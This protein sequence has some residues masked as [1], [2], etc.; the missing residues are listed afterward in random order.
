LKEKVND[1]AGAILAGGKSSR[2]GGLD[3]TLIKMDDTIITQ[4]IVELFNNI[5]E[6]VILVTNS[7]DNYKGYVE[8]IIIMADLIKDVGP[9]GGIHAGLSR[10]KKEAVFFI[11]CDMPFVHNAFIRKEIDCFRHTKSDAFLPRIGPLIEPLCAVYKKGLKENL[12]YFIKSN[13]NY[14]IRSFLQTVNVSY[15]DLENNP[16]HRKIF[17]NLNTREDLKYIRGA[18]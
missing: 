6:E 8:D 7:P 3:K 18:G 1:I 16:Y 4:N 9:L 5:F 12:H 14:S 11:A 10:T 2:M 15:W 17:T 13:D